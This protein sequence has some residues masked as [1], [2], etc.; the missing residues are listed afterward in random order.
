M[1]QVLEERY[2]RRCQGCGEGLDARLRNVHEAIGRASTGSLLSTSRPIAAAMGRRVFVLLAAGVAAVFALQAGRELA[3]LSGDGVAH[4]RHIRFRRE[5]G[6]ADE[7]PGAREACAALNFSVDF[8]LDGFPVGGAPRVVQSWRELTASF[9]APVEFNGWN[10]RAAPAAAAANWSFWFT[11]EGSA[12]GAAWRPITTRPVDGLRYSLYARNIGTARFRFRGPAARRE[13][14]GEA[15]LAEFD[16]GTSWWTVLDSVLAP[17]IDCATAAALAAAG[18]TGVTGCARWILSA[19]GALGCLVLAASAAGN[20]LGSGAVGVDDPVRAW[21]LWILAGGKLALALALALR[22]SLARDL[23]LAHGLVVACA[24]AV[25]AL[26]V[27]RL[28]TAELAASP[29]LLAV[30][31]LVLWLL[32]VTMQ[33]RSGRVADSVVL[34]D[35][36]RYDA[37]WHGLAAGEDDGE[38]ACG[39]CAARC[40]GIARLEAQTEQMALQCDAELA[41]QRNR[42]RARAP[43]RTPSAEGQAQQAPCDCP[44]ERRLSLNDKDAPAAVMDLVSTPL[45]VSLDQ[46]F[47]QAEGAHEF[48]KAKVQDWALA[49]DGRFPVEEPGGGLRFERW[50]ELRRDAAALGRVQWAGLKSTERAL[51]KLLRCYS[52][53]PSQLLDC[54]RQR[55]VF[56]GPA[57]VLACLE[58]AARDPDVVVVRVKNRLHG[59]YDA[60][61]TAGY[62]DV[63]LNV[64]VD[65][66]ETRRLGIETH[67]CEVQLALAAFASL[68]VLPGVACLSPPVPARPH[69][70]RFWQCFIPVLPCPVHR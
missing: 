60:R 67:V 14:A 40:S 25:E 6:A 68:Q 55:I 58:A 66:P 29:P 37:A 61:Q 42:E 10:V 43:T 2:R 41:R 18:A 5:A 22:E 8:V 16:L 54:C 65:T 45:V 62:R 47:A 28:L 12:D 53:D 33:A 64:R 59:G 32:L 31:E 27:G 36:A 48:L 3:A 21:S 69:S 57:G 9:G 17:L 52:N 35:Q 39:P 51:E 23:L 26:A 44:P 46:L 4:A 34:H 20:A 56:D 49:S 63:L 30:S 24:D 1:R 7:L 38:A 15:I 19:G 11:V 50:A 70:Q 13:P